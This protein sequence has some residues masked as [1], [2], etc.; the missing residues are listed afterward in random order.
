VLE[1][2]RRR[3]LLVDVVALA[4]AERRV[5]L[6]RG[7][8]N[9]LD[10]RVVE[11]AAMARVLEHRQGLAAVIHEDGAA[12]ELVP[13][14][15]GVRR[16]GREEEAV[17]LVDLREVDGGRLL[18]LLERA[19]SLRGRRLADVHG[20]VEQ[21]LDRRAPGRRHRVAGRQVLLGEEAAGNGGDQR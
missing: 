17:H 15:P 9:R 8:V 14:E 6:S 5:H 11:A 4:G 7:H 20:A 1:L 18:A 16:P 12:A 3:P 21:P 19:E 10:R 2:L 13:R